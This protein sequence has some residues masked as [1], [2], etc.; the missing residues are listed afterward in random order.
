MKR[1]ILFMLLLLLVLSSVSAKSTFKALAF[2][3]VLPGTGELYMGD[4]TKGGIFLCT[5]AAIIFTYVRLQQERQWAID[6]YKEFALSKAGIATNNEDWYYQRIQNWESSSRYNQSI[7]RDARNYYLIYQN[8][9]EGYQA[10]LDDHLVPD[11]MTWDWDTDANWKKYRAM[12]RDKQ[13]YEIYQNFAIAALILN[14]LVSVVDITVNVPRYKKLA[15]G[16]SI[17]PDV[18]GN[19]VQIRYEYRF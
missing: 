2:S 12:R 15:K 9:P 11:D 8:D 5:E 18:A 19:G 13:N 16:F 3:A 1:T 17:S 6:S 7:Y 4:H 14:R 10:Y